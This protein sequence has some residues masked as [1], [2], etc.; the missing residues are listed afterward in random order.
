MP[1]VTLTR[2]SSRDIGARDL[3]VRLDEEPERTVLHGEETT[4]DV[5]PGEHTLRI[6]NRLYSKSETF[7]LG[8]GET[9]RFMGANVPAGGIFAFI[10]FSMTFAYK[11]KLDRIDGHR[12]AE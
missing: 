7:T 9:A 11:V 1:T 8:D 5:A 10:V 3:Y 2:T 4:F 12:A 6:T